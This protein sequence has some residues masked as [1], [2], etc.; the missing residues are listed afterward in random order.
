MVYQNSYITSEACYISALYYLRNV[1]YESLVLP[2]NMLS[3]SRI[4]KALYFHTNMSSLSLSLLEKQ[5]PFIREP[6]IY[7]KEKWYLRALY[8]L[9]M[10][11][12][13]DLYY[14]RNG[15]SKSIV[16]P[17]KHVIL[18]PCIT[19]ETCYMYLRDLY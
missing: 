11:F 10:R 12:L 9:K 17:E 2:E 5:L 7:T 8:Y 19:R 14:Q 3:E 16:S 18:A 13:R 6:C 15:V 4:F 1:L